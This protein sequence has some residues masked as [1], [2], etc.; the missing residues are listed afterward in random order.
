VQDAEMA[1][2][3]RTESIKVGGVRRLFLLGEPQS[4]PTSVILSLHGTRSR[5]SEQARLSR[6]VAL[7][8]PAGVVVAFPEA[9]QP[10]GRGY[11]WNPALDLEYLSKLVDQFVERFPGAGGKVC[12]TGMSG[13]ARMSCHFAARR[14]DVVSMVGA[15]AGLRAPDVTLA[16]A[17]PIYAFHGTADR[18]NPYNGSGTARWNESVPEAARQWAVANGVGIPPATA[19]VTANVSTTR[20]GSPG[21]P[22]EVVLW[23]VRSGGHTWPGSPLGV[24]GRLFLGKT[25]TEIDATGTILA[26]PHL[27][28]R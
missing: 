23:T 8:V 22:N 14:P 16:R 1:S 17:V 18:I 28:R 10:I 19:A 26:S 20:Y 4:A 24:L 12:V 3:L 15:I 21:A 25:T 9:V 2:T 11:E 27:T 7:A 13:G 5:A 6:L